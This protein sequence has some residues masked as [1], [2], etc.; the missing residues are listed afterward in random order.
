LGEVGGGW[1]IWDAEKK[2]RGARFGG[3]SSDGI[4]ARFGGRSK[5]LDKKYG[6]VCI[7]F[8]LRGAKV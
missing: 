4:V 7:W 6:G 1:D 3:C 5:G 2:K 8:G